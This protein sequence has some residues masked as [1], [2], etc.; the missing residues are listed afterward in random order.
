V[1]KRY[2]NAFVAPPKYVIGGIEMDLFCPRHYITLQAANSPFVQKNPK[3][4]SGKDLFVAMRICSTKSW[5]DSIKPLTFF[6]RIKYLLIDSIPERQSQAFV[7]FGKYISSS[8]S[9]PKVWVKNDD[10]E[11]KE[12]KQNNI[13]ETISMAVI[14]MTKF[15]FSEEDAWNIPFSKAVWYSTIYASQEGSDIKIIT[16]EDEE[17]ES[18]ELEALH[19]FEE[20]IKKLVALNQKKGKK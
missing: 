16:T 19:K 8:L 9:V 20:N 3:G 18:K 4:L 1:D 15:G 5:V 6:E 10:S 14:L 13:P 2:I 17:S 7:D 11:K 12:F